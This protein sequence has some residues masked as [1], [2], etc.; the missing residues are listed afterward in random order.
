MPVSHAGSANQRQVLQHDFLR[1]LGSRNV[2]RSQGA[3]LTKYLLLFY[4][5]ACN[6]QPSA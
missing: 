3:S 1:Q 4:R 5:V 6:A 2:K